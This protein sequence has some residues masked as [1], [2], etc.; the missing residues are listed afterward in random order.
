MLYPP[1][2][3]G[4][5]HYLTSVLA[6]IKLILRPCV[7]NCGMQTE[8]IPEPYNTFMLDVGEGHHVYVEESGNRNGIPAISFYGGPGGRCKPNHRLRFDSARF[9]IILFDQRNCG[10]STPTAIGDPASLQYN[11]PMAI[12][13]D[14]EKIRAHL[15]ITKW[16][17]FGNSWGS[18]LALLYAINHPAHVSSVT[19]RALFM[20]QENDWHWSVEGARLFAPTAY[21]AFCALVPGRTTAEQVAA[22]ADMILMGPRAKALAAARI[23]L[24]LWAGLEVLSVPENSKAMEMPEDDILNRGLLWAH[25]VKNH[26]FAKGW[27][28]TQA[29]QNA[30]RH[31]PITM[32]HGRCDVGC[33]IKNVYEM[34]SVYPHIQV[35]VA[36]NGGH[37]ID[38]DGNYARLLSA[39]VARIA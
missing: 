31:L 25:M 21:A 14:V 13:G 33:P 35:S 17:V 4:H 2:L 11:S 28:A 30:L 38:L 32:V 29:A 16:H 3:Q 34:Q 22:L 9:R 39:A 26:T 8:I 23:N 27:T 7:L 1:E 15:G 10:Q 19:L 37:D 12:I 18:A 6:K 36:E 5:A 24:D 20:A